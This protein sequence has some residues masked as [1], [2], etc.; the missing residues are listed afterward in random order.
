MTANA[1]TIQSIKYERGE[2]GKIWEFF[3]SAAF[4]GN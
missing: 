2:V 1:A 3:G 4:C